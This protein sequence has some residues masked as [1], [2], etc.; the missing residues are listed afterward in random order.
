MNKWLMNKS[1]KQKKSKSDSFSGVSSSS[2]SS[3]QM[4]A[5]GEQGDE[6]TS[7]MTG[8]EKGDDEAYT[9][10]PVQ[11]K[12]KGV[13]LIGSWNY[14][15]QLIF[16]YITTGIM[17]LA[18]FSNLWYANFDLKN[19]NEIQS[20]ST[21][22]ISLINESQET[23]N[24]AVLGKNN[25]LKKL[26]GL[27]NNID[28]QVSDLEEVVGSD[29]V[30]L[31]N[32]KKYWS[33]LK[34]TISQINSNS[35]YYKNMEQNLLTIS[36]NSNKMVTHINDVLSNVDKDA[37]PESV[38]ISFYKVSSLLN[39]MS[40]NAIQISH[41]DKTKNVAPATQLWNDNNEVNKH[42][43]EINSVANNQISKGLIKDL[44]I[45]YSVTNNLV[46]TTIKNISVTNNLPI[47]IQQINKVSRN[48]V[49]N[50]N[51]LLTITQKLNSSKEQRDMVSIALG[52]FFLLS[53]ILLLLIIQRKEK[54][55]HFNLDE[56][57]ST[58]KS[59]LNRL[60]RDIEILAGGDLTH[61]IEHK[62]DDRLKE[63]KQN[64]NIV[65]ERIRSNFIDIS[66]EIEF[67]FEIEKNAR[68]TNLGLL[69]DSKIKISNL[70][71][72]FSDLKKITE[73]NSNIKEKIEESSQKISV[74]SDNLKE[75]NMEARRINT[76]IVANQKIVEETVNRINHLEESAKDI[77]EL[78]DVLTELSQR[79]LVLAV[80]SSI[81][82]AK[83]A[84]SGS[85]GFQ[86]ISEDM[87]LIAEKIEENVKKIGSLSD[88][89]NTDIQSTKVAIINI[90]EGIKNY[91]LFVD[92]S[93]NKINS[94]ATNNAM[95]SSSLESVAIN[96]NM[97]RELLVNVDKSV[98][99]MIEFL[100]K[101]NAGLK[102]LDDYFDE[103]NQH[104]LS[105]RRY[106]EMFKIHERNH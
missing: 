52:I 41:F 26:P 25:A 96:T 50:L 78:V 58:Y 61:K 88:S 56:L 82:S 60:K 46:K 81:Q 73:L 65:I 23:I 49:D 27:S 15:K 36:D 105:S 62:V 3:E 99:N 40:K 90:N 68:N 67:V 70:P 4:S 43:N 22:L 93:K 95:I 72:E 7:V 29:D 16:C 106:L 64:I 13:P 51:S 54:E 6:I 21:K 35:I 63:Y 12:G 89:T 79:T 47:E 24:N 33:T 102:K 39:N 103:S 66:Q 14:K 85:N 42:L 55:T 2:I 38:V 48:A 8:I 84:G 17:A 5:W 37:V 28:T 31:S 57:K 69:K 10:K 87:K 71:N 30:Y 83:Y 91:A 34:Q 100:Y 44:T 32:T 1:K 77:A 76:S 80:Q 45:N 59:S 19:Q 11:P 104:V 53:L 101:E 9:R 97:Q 94:V 92:L 74:I 18:L 20:S 86:L 75:T 98:S